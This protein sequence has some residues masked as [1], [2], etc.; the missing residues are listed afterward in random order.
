MFFHYIAFNSNPYRN[1]SFFKDVIAL[2]QIPQELRLSPV[3]RLSPW[4]GYFLLLDRKKKSL[5]MSDYQGFAWFFLL[6]QWSAWGS[7]VSCKSLILSCDF[8]FLKSF[9]PISQ[10]DTFRILRTTLWL[11]LFAKVILF[12]K[13][14]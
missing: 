13:I 8:Q 6:F 10:C 12:L 7:P 1:E 3:F 11:L 14:H 9:P 2:N 5:I 4:N